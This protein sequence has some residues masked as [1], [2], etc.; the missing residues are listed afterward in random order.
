MTVRSAGA[1]NSDPAR[2][3]DPGRI[4]RRTAVAA[5]GGEACIPAWRI[6][7]YIS[8]A[9]V[10]PSTPAPS[11]AAAGWTSGRSAPAVPPGRSLVV[12]A[13]AAGRGTGRRGW[14]KM[15]AATAGECVT[16]QGR[17][18]LI[19]GSTRPPTGSSRAQ[20][21][22]PPQPR[23]EVV[24]AW[25]RRHRPACC[26]RDR[27]RPLSCAS[28][29]VSIRPRREYFVRLHPIHKVGENEGN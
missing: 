3:G 7:P 25:A 28:C 16:S 24:R 1:Q 23:A 29:P 6:L 9:V 12:V 4:A 14:P 8:S 10:N 2:C 26:P 15:S 5:I 17:A 11:N 21:P 18:C 20:A 13:K 27:L 22:G 19:N